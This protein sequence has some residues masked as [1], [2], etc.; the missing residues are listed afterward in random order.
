MLPASPSTSL[1]KRSPTTKPASVG[2]GAACSR[3]GMDCDVQAWRGL[4]LVERV[5]SDRV[6]E[7]V[8]IWPDDTV[9][10]VRRCACGQLI[11]R[12]SSGPVGCSSA[13]VEFEAP[14]L[15]PGSGAQ[16]TSGPRPQPAITLRPNDSLSTD[17]NR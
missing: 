3:C 16:P 12:K 4:D 7:F 9:I 8:T 10:E 11:A 14:K 5:A 15:L 2:K 13:T 17:A 6:R 1:S